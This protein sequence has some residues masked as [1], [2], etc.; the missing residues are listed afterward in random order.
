MAEAMVVLND[1]CSATKPA[2]P[3]HVDGNDGERKAVSVV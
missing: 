3:G 2:E 1:T